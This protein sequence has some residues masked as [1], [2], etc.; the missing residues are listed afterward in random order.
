LPTVRDT[1]TLPLSQA[2]ATDGNRDST[3]NADNTITINNAGTY[4]VLLSVDWSPGKGHDAALRSYGVRR[5]RAGSSAIAA[6]TDGALTKIADTDEHLASQDMPGS[7][8]AKTV[9]MPAPPLGAHSSYT[10]IP[11]APG[12]IPV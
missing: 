10:P 12:T 4:R 9:R 1:A 6:S 11:W 2:A 3:L 7:A 5:R 8:T